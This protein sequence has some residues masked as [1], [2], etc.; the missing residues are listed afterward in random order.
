MILARETHNASWVGTT[1]RD[2]SWIRSQYDDLSA[3]AVPSGEW[4][5]AVLINGR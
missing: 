3:L 5:G 2:R 1:L 4:R